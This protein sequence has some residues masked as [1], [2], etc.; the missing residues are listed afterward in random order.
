MAR[1]FVLLCLVGAVSASQEAL[2]GAN[3]IRKVVTLMETMQSKIEAEAKKEDELFEK[4]ECYCKKTAEKL[5]DGIAKA[6]MS[7]NV[8]PEEIK[9]K[10]AKLKMLQQAVEDLK[11]EK[12]GEEESLASAKATRDKEHNSFLKDEKDQTE[13]ENAAEGAIKKLGS[14]QTDPDKLPEHKVVKNAGSFLS[15]LGASVFNQK[16]TAFLQGQGPG[17]STGEVTATSK[18]SKRSPRNDGGKMSRMTQRAPSNMRFR[19]APRKSQ[20]KLFLRRWQRKP[21]KSEI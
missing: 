8:G 7:S 1:S 21:K 13:T 4:F 15:Q 10:E 3:P 5:E 19:R 20:S 2:A 11:N 6:E 14:N 16:L 17:A 12:I 9:A 18:M